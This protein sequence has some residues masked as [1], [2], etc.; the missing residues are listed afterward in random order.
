MSQNMALVPLILLW[1]VRDLLA[2]LAERMLRLNEQRQEKEREFLRFIERTFKISQQPDPKSGKRGLDAF[3]NKT[4]LFEY[5]GDYQK[6]TPVRP[7]KEIHDVLSKN[8]NRCALFGDFAS[9]LREL[10][11]EYE[12]NA[13]S[14]EPL[15][16]HLRATD[17]LIDQ[18]VYRLYGLN[19]E[20][21]ALVE[22]MK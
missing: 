8:R 1:R 20:E 6:G 11:A 16:D 13:A 10:E 18:I 4:V 3:S 21:I 7:F 2:F 5:A 15:K 17:E 19:D 22:G 12:K 9:A 14:L